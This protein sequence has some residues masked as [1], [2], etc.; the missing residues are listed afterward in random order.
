MDD[1]EVLAK[2]RQAAAQLA[3]MFDGATDNV[4]V[5]SA[6]VAL[7]MVVEYEA[8]RSAAKQKRAIAEQLDRD[9][10][11]VGDGAAAAHASTYRTVA[12]TLDEVR[13]HLLSA[14]R[15]AVGEVQS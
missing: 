14:L 7:A 6:R 2:V 10:A 5:A 11:N 15:A 1:Q 13:A 3:S 12:M 8:V 9:E 4:A